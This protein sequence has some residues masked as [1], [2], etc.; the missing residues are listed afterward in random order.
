MT[1]PKQSTRSIFH[2]WYCPR[3]GSIPPRPVSCCDDMWWP[4]GRATTRAAPFERGSADPRRQTPCRRAS[5]VWVPRHAVVCSPIFAD[6]MAAALCTDLHDL[7]ARIANVHRSDAAMA[8]SCRSDAIVHGR[9]R[10]LPVSGRMQMELH[11]RI[12][13]QT[14]HVDAFGIKRRHRGTA[15]H[16]RYVCGSGELR[17]GC[18]AG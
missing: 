18:Q 8:A 10:R 5:S 6:C 15:V 9:R 17:R 2:F 7:A 1:L 11:G 14:H 3:R 16:V 12:R 4:R 13:I